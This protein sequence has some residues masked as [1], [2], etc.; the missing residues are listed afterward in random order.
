[1][2]ERLK[3]VRTK[4]LCDNCLH[5]G[6]V[7]GSCPKTSFCKVKNCSLLRKHPTFLHQ[8][9]N[10][11][12]KDNPNKLTNQA[13]GDKAQSSFINSQALCNST[14]AGT[15]MTGLSIVPLKV[16]NTENDSFVETYTFLDPGSNTTFCTDQLLNR[17][18][19]SVVQAELSLATLNSDNIMRKCQQVALQVYDLEERNCVELPEVFSCPKLPVSAN[20]TRQQ[21]DVDR[22]Q[23]LEGIQLTSIYSDV[24]L[25]IGNDVVKA[26]EP[27]QVIESQ[28]G[29]HYAV[30][31]VL[32]WTINGPLGRKEMQTHSAN[33]IHSDVQLNE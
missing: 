9:N 14:G 24:D 28:D 25:L 5:E 31:T 4:E 10:E 8:K 19:I 12:N 27:K 6:H 11:H 20:D 3:F 29:G 32:G 16:R 21:S 26:L 13:S 30:R 15:P 23:H 18:G 7:A 1:M 2:E 17:L 22:L 33:R